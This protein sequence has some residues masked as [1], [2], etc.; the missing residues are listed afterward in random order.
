MPRDDRPFRVLHVV[1]GLGLGGAETLLYR[2]VTRATGIEHEVVCLGPPDWYSGKLEDAGIPV[3]HL[4]MTSLSGMAGKISRLRRLVRFSEADVIHSWTPPANLVTSLAA[5]RV[6]VPI[7]W[8]LHSSSLG[9]LGGKSRLAAVCCGALAR[10]AT[11]FVIFCSGATSKFYGKLGYGVADGAVV[12]NGYDLDQFF[13]DE[14]SRRV[15]RQALG[16]DDETFLIGGLSRWNR[17]KDVPTWLAAV[18]IARNRGLPVRAILLGHNLD[19]SNSDFVDALDA[20]G[21]AEIVQPLGRRGDVQELAR[22]MDVH[23]LTSRSEACPNVV[24]ETMLCGTPNIVTD[25]G[26][27]ALMLGGT[28]WVATA[29]D[30]DQLADEIEQAYHEW[31]QRPAEWERR[32]REARR[33]ITENFSFDRMVKVYESIWR[34]V[35]SGQP[36]SN[37]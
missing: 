29:G 31:K 36:I 14:A 8:S 37:E 13:P 9:P 20:A 7:I 19:P 27:A 3:S 16:V 25:V 18:R 17:W 5:A 4:D 26:D 23:L 34:K 24:A 21:C 30:P 28:G 12:H 15:S 11:D 6:R 32:R 22:A 2:M 1:H 33:R 10:W 35:G